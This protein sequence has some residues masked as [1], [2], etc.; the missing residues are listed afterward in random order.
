[1]GLETSS[2]CLDEC[3]FALEVRNVVLALYFDCVSARIGRAYRNLTVK[4]INHFIL[5]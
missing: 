1:M 4:E 5:D 2:S 3:V